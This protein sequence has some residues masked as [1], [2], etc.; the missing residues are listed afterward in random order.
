MA[1]Y[2]NFCKTYKNL[3]L[4]SLTLLKHIHKNAVNRSVVLEIDT[5]DEFTNQLIQRQSSKWENMQ[6]KS[7]DVLNQRK[8]VHKPLKVAAPES[9]DEEVWVNAVEL[10][11]VSEIESLMGLC[12]DGNGL[13]PKGIFHELM[14]LLAENGRVEGVV[15]MGKLYERFHPEVL[16]PGAICD[17]YL[18]EALWT[19]GDVHRSLDLFEDTYKN[20]AICRRQIKITLRY[21]MSNVLQN[22]GEAVLLTLIRFC[23]HLQE[24]YRDTFL[25]CVIWQMCFLSE[26][27]TDQNI[28]FELM[29]RNQKLRKVV[30]LRFPFVASLALNNHQT[31]VVYRLLEFLLKEGLKSEYSGVLLCL[32]DYKSKFCVVGFVVGYFLLVVY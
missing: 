9:A 11:N 17:I 14:S 2:S 12:V 27:F 13:P 30:Q 21:L 23:E 28:A 18:A 3:A 5:I 16:K 25:L 1:F 15:E 24:T 32:F 31:E 6:T 22:R 19:R 8:Y 29:E 7:K 10:K 4:P 26:W 20:H